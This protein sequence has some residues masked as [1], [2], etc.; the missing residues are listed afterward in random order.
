MQNLLIRFMSF[1]DR[2]PLA[3]YRTYIINAVLIMGAVLTGIYTQ[4]W[5]MASAVIG[6]AL[7]QIFSR[8]AVANQSAQLAYVESMIQTL[9]EAAYKKGDITVLPSGVRTLKDP[10]Q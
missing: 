7:S 8:E 6:F 4:E 1:I 10:P 9:S 2:T 3:G 5:T